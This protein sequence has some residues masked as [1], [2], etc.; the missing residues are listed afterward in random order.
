MKKETTLL[1][2]FDDDGFLKKLVNLL[3]GIDGVGGVSV[4]VGEGGVGIVGLKINQ[5]S[6][7]VKFYLIFS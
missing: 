3:I 1:N 5:I 6:F 7:N 2:D 4:P